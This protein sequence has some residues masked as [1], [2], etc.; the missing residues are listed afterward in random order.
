MTPTTQVTPG[1]QAVANPSDW[2]PCPLVNWSRLAAS[3][4]PGKP[5]SRSRLRTLRENRR[6]SA[7]VK[8]YHRGR[9]GVAGASSYYSVLS[10]WAERARSRGFDDDA[11]TLTSAASAL[12]NEFASLLTEYLSRH[13]FDQ[14]PDADFFWSMADKTAQVLLNQKTWHDSVVA[15]ASVAE[16]SAH[17]AHLEGSSMEGTPRSVDLPRH[18]AESNGLS[19]GS[20]V[21]VLSRALG[22]GAYVEVDQAVPSR[23]LW[24]AGLRSGYF[25]GVEMTASAVDETADKAELRDYD[26]GPGSPLTREQATRAW[27]AAR[28]AG[29]QP[30]PLRPAG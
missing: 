27:A 6:I 22:S 19:R 30:T 9:T 12:E 23:A 25:E 1:H 10:L 17:F 8:V 3:V 24:R 13:P 14:L 15:V 28:K 5:A 4:A 29:L 21:F 16:V 11:R 20:C 18:L 2:L 7:G 26:E